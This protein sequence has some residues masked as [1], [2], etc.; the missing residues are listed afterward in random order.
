MAEVTLIRLDFRL[1]HGQVAVKWSRAAKVKQIIVV[2]DAIAKDEFMISIF[3]MAAP[4]GIK[5]KVYSTE[6]LMQNWEKDQFGAGNAMVMFKTVD[7][8]YKAFQAGFPMA[9]LQ[10]GNMPKAEGKKPLGNE[11]FATEAEIG[12]L[13]EIQAAGTDITI[14]TIPEQM[15]VPFDRAAAGL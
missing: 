7:A 8:C 3:Q 12:R 2:D 10:L 6:K 9:K 1:V 15:C 5:V 11:V 14:Q 13:R 4:P